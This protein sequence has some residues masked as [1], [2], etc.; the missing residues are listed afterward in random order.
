MELRM[1]YELL[2]GKRTLIIGGLRSGKTKLTAEIV[3]GL[4]GQIGS[5]TLMDF[6]P[7]RGGVGLPLSNYMSVENCERPEG[8]HAPR[9]EGRNA[10]EVLRLA[11]DN[12]EKIRPILIS[13]L[14]RPTDA[15]VI[16]DLTIYLHS[17]D[18]DLLLKCIYS[19]KTFVGNAYYGKDFDDK[20]SG[21]NERERTLVEELMKAMDFVIKMDR[22]PPQPKR[23]KGNKRAARGDPYGKDRRGLGSPPLAQLYSQCDPGENRS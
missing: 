17:G 22:S 20:G 18:P 3:R 1:R 11:R 4:M 10:E 8:L 16:N 23:L 19:S 15:L 21:L 13:F 6:A 7:G 12:E 14:S 5:L 2:V 9:I